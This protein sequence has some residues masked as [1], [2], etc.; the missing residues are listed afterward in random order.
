MTPVN[1]SWNDELIKQVQSIT[2]W[3][4]YGAEGNGKSVVIS[5]EHQCTVVLEKLK[6][7]S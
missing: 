1:R 3:Q 4:L 6:S 5:N 2:T 7:L